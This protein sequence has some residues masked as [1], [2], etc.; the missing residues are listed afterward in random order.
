MELSHLKSPSSVSQ[1][2]ASPPLHWCKV[3]GKYFISM[4]SLVSHMKMHTMDEDLFCG[5]CGKRFDSTES[6]QVHLQTHS[7]SES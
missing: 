6:M 4:V 7:E 1:S 2:P 3:C 5:V